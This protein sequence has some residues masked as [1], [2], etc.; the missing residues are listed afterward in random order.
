MGVYVSVPTA[1]NYD[2]WNRSECS[3]EESDDVIALGELRK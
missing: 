2:R 1:K 3:D